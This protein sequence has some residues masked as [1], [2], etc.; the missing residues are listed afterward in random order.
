MTGTSGKLVQCKHTTGAK[1][2]G[3]KAIQEIH[4]A[5]VKYSEELGKDIDTLIFATNA[6]VLSVKS[7]KLAEQYHVQIFSYSEISTLLKK[8]TIT[9]KMVLIRLGKSRLK[10]G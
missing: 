5:R 6:K 9:F 7:R 3:Y 4:S 10:I 1:Y 8:H 2:D